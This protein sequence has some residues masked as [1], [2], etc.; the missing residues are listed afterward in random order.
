[1]V[2][3]PRVLLSQA[4]EPTNIFDTDTLLRYRVKETLS[5][6]IDTIKVRKQQTTAWLL[7]IMD[8]LEIKK[9]DS[10]KIEE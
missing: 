7:E 9:P 2:F 8:G 6:K 4:T 10:L 5:Q 1:M 3:L